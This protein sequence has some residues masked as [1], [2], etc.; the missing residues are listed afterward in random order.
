MCWT[1]SGLSVGCVSMISQ[2]PT[3]W[4]EFL[5]QSIQTALVGGNEQATAWD[6][7]DLQGRQ[8][9]IYH[10]RDTLQHGMLPV[11]LQDKTVKAKS[12]R[13]GI[14][15]IVNKVAVG[16][17]NPK[18]LSICQLQMGLAPWI[19]WDWRRGAGG[20]GVLPPGLCLLCQAVAGAAGPVHT[21][22]LYTTFLHS[23]D[24]KSGLAQQENHFPDRSNGECP[25][26]FCIFVI[27]LA[28]GL[29][30]LRNISWCFLVAAWVQ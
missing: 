24:A 29:V 19:W 13:L 25:L 18:S 17:T 1:T 16:F 3:G 7:R 2:M 5:A 15:R 11:V 9:R 6:L 12:G 30:V 21:C 4:E 26:D 8:T 10:R 22:T 20:V 28:R 27:C 23:S 14:D